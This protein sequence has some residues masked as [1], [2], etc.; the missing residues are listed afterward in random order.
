[1]ELRKRLICLCRGRGRRKS[2]SHS[3]K[4]KSPSTTDLAALTLRT[5]KEGSEGVQ[6]ALSQFQEW[7][8]FFL[9]TGGGDIP[10]LVRTLVVGLA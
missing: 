3:K 10:C 5:T 2:K 9:S 4:V 8:V 1:M 7:L 6:I